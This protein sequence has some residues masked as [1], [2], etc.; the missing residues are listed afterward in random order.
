MNTVEGTDNEAVKATVTPTENGTHLCVPKRWSGLEVSAGQ[1]SDT[2]GRRLLMTDWAH[3]LSV[4]VFVGC[5][6]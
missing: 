4:W 3:Y 5:L 6:R 1:V 2:T